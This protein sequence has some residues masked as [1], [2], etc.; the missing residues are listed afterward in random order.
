MGREFTKI[1][2]ILCPDYFIALYDVAVSFW[3]HL[4]AQPFGFP[5]LW[6]GVRDLRQ[7]PVDGILSS[8]IVSSLEP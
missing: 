1:I 8:S 7:A 3:R 5:V 4:P 2:P 6:L